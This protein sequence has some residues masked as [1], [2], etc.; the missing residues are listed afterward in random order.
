MGPIQSFDDLVSLLQRRFW[1]ILLVGILGSVIGVIS[2]INRPD[3]FESAAVIQVELPTVTEAG[4]AVATPVNAL[5]LLQVIEQRLTT[6]DNILALIDRHGLFDDAPATS[7]ED[8]VAAMRG[9]IRFQSV[10]TATGGGLSAIIIV[11]QAGKADD[12]AAVANDLAQSV[13]DMGAADKR[14]TADATF[15][16]FKEEEARIWSEL[17]SLEQQIAQYREANQ[18]SLPAARENRRDEAIQL[19]AA[20]REIDQ[21]LAG[22][23]DE[24]S[25]I[26]SGGTLRAT[27]RRRLD[28]IA[29]RKSVLTAQRAPL[30]TRKTE[31]LANLG[32]AAEVDRALSTFDRQLRQLQEQ[33]SVVATR[34]A[35]AETTQRLAERR[36]NE[37]FAL[38]ERAITP[39]YP[40]GSGNR[41]RAI[42]AAIASFGAGFVLAFML[43]V[44]KPIIRSSAQLERELNL[45]PIVAIPDLPTK[46]RRPRKRDEVK[47]LIEN[48]LSR[49]PNAELSS[50]ALMI[51]GGA[52]IL[53]MVAF[54]AVT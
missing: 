32:N 5:Q 3:V 41:K 10:S 4:Q 44:F 27:D 54:A 36:Q 40:I 31:L 18:D 9:A 15:S 17:T 29:Q 2:A 48:G 19:E 38:L 49:L 33:Y 50:T 24:D 13:L 43:D 11:A 52:A 8:R 30:M 34:M 12:A 1:V 53:L 39:E 22:L 28:E 23:Q 6:R 7:L 35:E 20:L 25:R 16:F 51:G 47:S 46:A 14:A 37:R 26:R 45:R 21:E 42:A